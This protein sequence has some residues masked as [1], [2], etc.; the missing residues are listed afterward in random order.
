MRLRGE[1]P[2]TAAARETGV[3]GPVACYAAE[4]KLLPLSFALLGSACSAAHEPATRG[5]SDAAIGNDASKDAGPRETPDAFSPGDASGPCGP[6][7]VVTFL[8]HPGYD[9][10]SV[11]A[12]N[13][14]DGTW[15]YSV[16]TAHGTPVGIFLVDANTS[17]TACD[18]QDVAIGGGCA[19]GDVTATWNGIQITGEA[20]TCMNGGSQVS[21]TSSL[22]APAGEY[23]V[24]M[25]ANT[26]S[27]CSA[28]GDA[29][30]PCVS[31][32]FHYPTASEVVGTIP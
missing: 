27:D 11:S 32:P 6:Q 10:Y 5:T 15:W 28:T 4:M 24:T 20:S 14:G 19:T 21:C 29:G 1:T 30:N 31:V 13:P 23:V 26:A 12:G 16:A 2:V 25:C 8:M 7:S 17:C 9:S 3:V 22:C 18:P